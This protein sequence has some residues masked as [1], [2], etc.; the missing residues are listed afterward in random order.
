MQNQTDVI[1]GKDLGFKLI[2]YIEERYKDSNS[3]S[4][5]R[6]GFP[7]IDAMTHGFQKGNLITVCSNL[8]YYKKC[9]VMQLLHSIV[10]KEK[11][12]FGFFSYTMNDQ[13]FGLS[14]ISRGTLVPVSKIVAGMLSKQDLNKIQEVVRVFF[15]SQIVVPKIKSLSFEELCK[16]IR[17]TV[18]Q[19]DLRV[20]YIDSLNT[21]PIEKDTGSYK[22]RFVNI[23]KKLKMLAA[24]LDIIIITEYY[25]YE[26][27]KDLVVDDIN[28]TEILLQR[29]DFLYSYSDIVLQLQNVYVNKDDFDFDQYELEIHCNTYGLAKSKTL[30]FDPNIDVFS[31]EEYYH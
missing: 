17:E 11:S 24:E 23:V 9:F 12:S 3:I 1:T 2:E 5:V 15:E 19:Y 28:K 29:T 31:E 22:K 6:S 26:D 7:T 4:G 30:L 21:I 13:E 10:V 8:R 18:E 25:C 14:M 27:D 16:T 20:I